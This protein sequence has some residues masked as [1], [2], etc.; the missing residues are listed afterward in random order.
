MRI[1]V[2]RREP[3]SWMGST[4]DRSSRLERKSHW[5]HKSLLNCWKFFKAEKRKNQWMSWTIQR[6]KISWN[7]PNIGNSLITDLRGNSA[8]DPCVWKHDGPTLS[9]APG[10]LLDQSNKS[11]LH[12]HNMEML[13]KNPKSRPVSETHQKQEKCQTPSVEVSGVWKCSNVLIICLH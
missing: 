2:A 6:P 8:P 11:A 9:T 10:A 5:S 12:L 13:R 1:D 3:S 4:R 7:Y